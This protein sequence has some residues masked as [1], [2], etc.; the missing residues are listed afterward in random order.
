MLPGVGG[1]GSA[2]QPSRAEDSCAEPQGV[3]GSWA[4]GEVRTPPGSNRGCRV[5]QRQVSGPAFARNPGNNR[6]RRNR[7]CRRRAAAV[8]PTHV[9]EIGQLRDSCRE[10]GPHASR[11]LQPEPDP[12]LLLLLLVMLL[13]MIGAP[14]RDRRPA[15]DHGLRCGRAA[16][17]AAALVAAALVAAV[18]GRVG[19]RRRIA[20]S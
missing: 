4:K 18:W 9:S 13:P 17:V 10:R 20:G 1:S 19:E 6:A 2:V 8:S 16:L 15:W 3:P 12:L 7:H 5:A 11:P 14:E